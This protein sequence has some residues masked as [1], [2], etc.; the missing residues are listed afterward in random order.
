M[1]GVDCW[2]GAALFQKFSLSI[3]WYISA[4]KHPRMQRKVECIRAPPKGGRY[5]EIHPRRPRDFLRPEG[6]GKSPGWRG[7]ISHYLQRLRFGS[8][9][10]P[11]L[12]TP[13]SPQPSVGSG[14]HTGCFR[15]RWVQLIYYHPIGDYDNE[16]FAWVSCLDRLKGR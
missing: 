1:C 14:G 12:A 11:D 7:W 6:Q 5:W 9:S 8:I 15:C 13:L 4:L 2:N 3:R 10:F 16:E